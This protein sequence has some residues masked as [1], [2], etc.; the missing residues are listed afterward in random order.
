MDVDLRISA[1]T[2]RNTSG[3]H[4]LEWHCLMC[5]CG[6]GDGEGGGDRECP[7]RGRNEWFVECPKSVPSYAALCT[8][9]PRTSYVEGEPETEPDPHDST[10]QDNREPGQH[11]SLLLTAGSE[12]TEAT[13]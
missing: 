8:P 4:R 13:Y 2:G 10:T 12:F 3:F 11:C 7:I 9:A 5:V 6:G 1:M